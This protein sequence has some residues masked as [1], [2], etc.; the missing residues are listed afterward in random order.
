LLLA[1]V[2]E[3]Q[4]L[5]AASL[6]DDFASYERSRPR[7][8]NAARLGGNRQ[9]IAELDLSVP[10]KFVDVADAATTIRFERARLLRAAGYHDWAESE[11]RFG[12]R[13]GAEPH[14]IAM[15]M[16]SSA[17]TPAEGLRMMKTTVQDYLS[18]PFD[19]APRRFWLLLFP[20]PFRPA[21]DEFSE[22]RGLD[23]FMVAG[24]IRQESEFNP[25]GRSH[26]NA[27]GLT[28]IL[29]ST[30]RYLARRNGITPFSTGLL[31][32]PETN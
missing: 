28:Q 27:Y 22:Q 16:A 1:L 31:L 3:D 18:L 24:L 12:A 6:L 32:Q 30:G 25:A 9:H 11:L 21:L 15:E 7:R 5:V 10:S 2:V 14:L 19:S 23:P 17:E 20:L 13:N 29:P 8:Q 4:D 26:A